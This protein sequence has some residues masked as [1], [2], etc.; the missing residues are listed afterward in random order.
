MSDAAPDDLREQT[1]Q[2]LLQSLGGWSGTVITAIPPAV[3]VIANSIGGLREAIIAAIASGVVIALYRLIRRQSLQQ[4]LM[5]GQHLVDG[6][7]A[8]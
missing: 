4:V 7:H 5:G 2:Q 3:F 1:R 8:R 6:Q